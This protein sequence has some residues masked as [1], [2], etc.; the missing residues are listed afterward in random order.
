MKIKLILI[1]IIFSV[2]YSIQAQTTFTFDSV[3]SKSPLLTKITH[4]YQKYKLQIIYTQIDRDATGTPHFTTHTFHLDSSNYFYCAS[5]VKLPCAI[6]ALEKTKALRIYSQTIMFTDSSNAC[7]HTV[8]IDTTSKNNYPSVA[9]YIKRMALVSDN[10]AYSRIYEFLGTDYI[11]QRL[12]ELGYPN[13]RIVHRFDGG[14]VGKENTNTNTV[15]FYD[16]KLKPIASVPNQISEINYKHPLGN[17]KIGNAYINSKNKKVN[18][19]KDFSYMNYMSLEN[20]HSI[21]QR[22][23]FNDYLPFEK[24]YNLIND[25]RKMLIQYLTQYPRE[26]SYPTY[27]KSYYDSYKKYFLF[28]DSKKN[29]T[30]SDIKITNIVGQSYGFMSDCAYITNEKKSIEFMLSAVI[31]TNEDGVINDGKYEYNSIAL[32]FLA[33]LGRQIYRYEENRKIK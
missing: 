6:L 25:D 26:S 7:Q 17:V 15:V 30:D 20:T 31:Y 29:I 1:F 27:N 21:L 12:N 13:I 8:K 16:D 14:C 18:E 28:G 32:P 2:S 5:L 4:Q 11:H 19:P 23:I 33:E 24:R 3:F 9:Q 22:I 10:F